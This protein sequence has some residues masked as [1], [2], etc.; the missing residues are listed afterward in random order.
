MH[1][2]NLF[3]ASDCTHDLIKSGLTSENIF[4]NSTNKSL[5]VRVLQV[6]KVKYRE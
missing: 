2:M 3:H 4:Y 5:C 1:T 6:L